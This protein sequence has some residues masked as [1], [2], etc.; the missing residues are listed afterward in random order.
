MIR[1][2]LVDDHQLIRD[3]LRRACDATEDL[4]VVAEAGSLAEARTAV[5]G[6]TPDVVVLDVRLPDGTGLELAGELRQADPTLGIVVLTMDPSEEV[7][8]SALTA[9][10]SALVGKDAPRSDVIDAAR[11]ACRSPL[12]FTA[13][14]LEEVLRRQRRDPT[15]VPQL[16]AR[17]REIMALVADGLAAGAIARQL[18]IS[19]STIKTHLSRIY[20]KLGA[21]NRA[22]A[23]MRA[24]KWGLLPS[25][26]VR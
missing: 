2:A 16:S 13:R 21:A 17:E 3:G 9:G 24:V 1:I 5:A 26:Q 10:A 14:D 6:A 7:L 23:V 15:P 22:Q 25:R 19:E 11:R 8:L 12:T 4:E 20:S 18:F